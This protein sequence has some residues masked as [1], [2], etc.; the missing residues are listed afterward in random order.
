MEE[1]GSKI[2]RSEL[3]CPGHSAKMMAKAAASN[4]D[5]VIFDL[6]DACAVSQKVFARGEVIRAFRELDFG[7]KVRAFRVNGLATPFFFRDLWDVIAGAGGFVDAVVVPKVS[8][9]EEIR[10]VDRLLS[11]AEA[12]TGLPLGRIELEVLIES[13][14]GVLRAESI[15]TASPRLKS[16]I[17]GIADYAGDIGAKQFADAD[18][19]AL[20]H[21]PKSQ[22]VAAA[23]A[24][25]ID[26]I[27]NVTVQLRD[28]DRVA[29]DSEAGA[30]LGFDG[31]W[32]IHPSHV[33]PI[34]AAYSPTDEALRRALRIVE[35]YQRA[36]RE[37]GVGA[38][39]VGDEMVDAAT[40]VVERKKVELGR[41]IGRVNDRNELVP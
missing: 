10:F 35:A 11:M 19:F 30:R 16:L 14:K 24:A 40:L 27:D 1:A 2:R 4:A 31:K 38:I 23:K 6:E 9:A 28:L 33:E 18:E 39:V 41:R 13:A 36:D 29:R 22:L 26:A 34:H 37:S 12:E 5:E 25:G 3:V 20:F 15:A 17:F 32:A 21:Y 8:S 7:T